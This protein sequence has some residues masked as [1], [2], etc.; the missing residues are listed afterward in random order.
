MQLDLQ[1]KLVVNQV[2]FLEVNRLFVA[3]VTTGLCLSYGERTCYLNK[4][5][6]FNVCTSIAP[7]VC[8]AINR[9]TCPTP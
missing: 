4:L 1:L 7:F 2:A 6:I 8:E 9:P 3:A 5:K